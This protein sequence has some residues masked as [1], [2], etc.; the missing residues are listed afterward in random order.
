MPAPGVIWGAALA[1]LVAFIGW[2]VAQAKAT[3][4]SQAELK[5]HVKECDKRQLWIM[6][7]MNSLEKLLIAIIDKAK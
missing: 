3:W 2:A 4:D 5:A 1:A 6:D 7:K